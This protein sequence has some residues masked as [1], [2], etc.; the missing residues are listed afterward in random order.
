MTD[1]SIGLNRERVTKALVNLSRQLAVLA[2]AGDAISDADALDDLRALLD[3][4]QGRTA[5]EQSQPVLTPPAYRFASHVTDDAGV[6]RMSVLRS[7]FTVCLDAME[8]ATHHG[9]YRS[10]A[11]T[12]LEEACM[13]AVKSVTHESTP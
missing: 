1:L 7:A 8:A 13:W 11:T 3:L 10:L 6:M 12:A 5:S 9:R 2:D 4:V